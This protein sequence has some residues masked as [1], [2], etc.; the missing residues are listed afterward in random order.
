MLAC[1]EGNIEMVDLLLQ[2]SADPNLQQ[3]VSKIE[4]LYYICSVC[5]ETLIACS[6]RQ[7]R[8]YL[9]LLT[10]CMLQPYTFLRN[11]KLLIISV[12]SFLFFLFLIF[13]M[14]NTSLHSRNAGF[15]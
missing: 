2:Y 14:M 13:M 3:P 1:D 4:V 7:T 6:I 9:M 5:G 12:P 11:G 15:Q 8:I 10:V